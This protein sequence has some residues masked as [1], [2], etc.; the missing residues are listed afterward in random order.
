MHIT[1]MCTIYLV[2]Y[3]LYKRARHGSK[4]GRGVYFAE[5]PAYA[6]RFAGKAHRTRALLLAG[7]LPG[8]HTRGKEGLLEA[9]VSTTGCRYDST[10]DDTSRP[11]LI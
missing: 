4:L 5:D 6:W 10:C 3:M 11:V 9:P 7:V 1:H 8:R 2:I